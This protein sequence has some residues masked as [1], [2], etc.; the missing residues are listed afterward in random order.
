MKH[1]GRPICTR[2]TTGCKSLQFLFDVVLDPP[3]CRGTLFE[4]QIGCAGITVVG[5]AN[6]S[7]VD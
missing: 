5:K 1:F 7:G 6:A 3:D 4:N 2:E